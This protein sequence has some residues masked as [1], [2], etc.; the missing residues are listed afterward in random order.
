MR[1]IFKFAFRLKPVVEVASMDPAPFDM[2]LEGS[3]S[4]LFGTRA[5][6]RWNTLPLGLR[7]NLSGN[8]F[9]RNIFRTHVS[10]LRFFVD[11]RI[12]YATV[13]SSGINTHF[14]H[15]PCL[16]TMSGVDNVRA[17]EAQESQDRQN[18]DEQKRHHAILP[19]YLP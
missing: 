4:N 11:S 6:Q 2:D 9:V 3:A 14:R 10:C 12:R 7:L 19:S 15:C 13:A 5:P 18:S 8:F 16:A 17:H 1:T